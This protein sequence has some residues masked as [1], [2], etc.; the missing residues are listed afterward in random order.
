MCWSGD[1][2][3]CLDCYTFQSAVRLGCSDA[4]EAWAASPRFCFG[5]K[6]LHRVRSAG[7]GLRVAGPIRI[8]RRP[9][10][11]A[12]TGEEYAQMVQDLFAALQP[13][14]VAAGLE[15][16]DVELKAGVLQV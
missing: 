16:V 10:T 13:V 7:R 4:D 3:P 14:V 1:P 15:L 2:R 12:P 6:H 8:P 5:R 9:T 11:D